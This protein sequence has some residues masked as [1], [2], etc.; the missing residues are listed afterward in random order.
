MP[1]GT[2]ARFGQNGP[3]GQIRIMGGGSVG[4]V[5][6][7]DETS[8]TLKL[9]DGGS[10]IVF[11][12]ASTTVNKMTAGSLEDVTSGTSVTVMGTPNQDGSL[13]AS[14]IQLRPDLPELPMRQ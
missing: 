10:K 6:S 4:E 14:Q 8:L 11:L 9:L 7:K 5:V 12:S 13:T 3:G 2:N 1:G